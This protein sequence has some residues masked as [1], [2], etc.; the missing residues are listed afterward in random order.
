MA[1]YVKWFGAIF[2]TTLLGAA[3]IDAGTE[4][5][6]GDRMSPSLGTPAANAPAPTH[7]GE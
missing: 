6:G 4:C 7:D 2:V 5:R 1:F 3:M